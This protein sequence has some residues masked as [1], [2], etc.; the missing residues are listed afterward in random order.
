MPTK[1]AQPRKIYRNNQTGLRGVYWHKPTQSY[2]IQR[3]LNGKRTTIAYAKTLDEAALILNEPI[4]QTSSPGI[5]YLPPQKQDPTVGFKQTHA[6]LIAEGKHEEAATVLA[7]IEIIEAQQA[8][9]LKVTLNPLRL[10]E[11]QE[12][13]IS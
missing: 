2:A 13:H 4:Q 10:K 3:L 5:I 1:P 6:A 11:Q 9:G 12:S 7:A 8:A